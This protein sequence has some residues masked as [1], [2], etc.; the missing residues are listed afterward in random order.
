LDERA[1]ALDVAGW[2]SILGP[3]ELSGRGTEKTVF[4]EVA[5][6]SANAMLHVR[7]LRE[8]EKEGEKKKEEE[9]R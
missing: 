7:Q 8:G 4:L 5:D 9:G 2:A 3:R 1:L 6:A